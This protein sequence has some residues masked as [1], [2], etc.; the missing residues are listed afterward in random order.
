MGLAPD[1]GVPVGASPTRS[2]TFGGRSGSTRTIGTASMMLNRRPSAT[3]M[4]RTGVAHSTS[5]CVGEDR[6]P[7]LGDGRVDRL[8][9][10]EDRV[11]LGR[12]E[13]RRAIGDLELHPDD[14]RD[15]A[16]DQARGDARERVVDRAA[17]ALA[18]VQDDELQRLAVADDRREAV[19][20]DDVTEAVLVLEQQGAFL[21]GAVEAAVA[22]EVED[23]VVA[24]PDL[25]VQGQQRRVLEPVDRDRVRLDRA[26]PAPSRGSRAPGPR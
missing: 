4:N 21:V 20:A 12:E 7:R 22:D 23:V 17:R 6:P 19:G 3:R 8:A 25:P 10:R 18:R 5:F 16:L 11:E 2:A 24:L 9:L 15:L 13:D 26:A 1:G 14:G